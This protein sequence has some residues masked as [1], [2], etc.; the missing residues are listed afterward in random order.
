MD[1]SKSSASTQRW[2][3]E[4]LAA[5]TQQQRSLRGIADAVAARLSQCPP[6]EEED[7]LRALRDR[8]EAAQRHSAAA[9]QSLVPLSVAVTAAP[10][11][12][13][14]LAAL[15]EERCRL[16]RDIHDGP[17]Q[18]LANALLELQYCQRLLERDPGALRG[19]LAVLSK[20]L[21]D[22]LVEVRRLIFDLRPP[23]LVEL[24]LIAAI[25][26]YVAEYGART[27][28]EASL[29]VRGPEE[30]LSPVQEAAVFRILQEALQNVRRHA[31]ARRVTVEIEDAPD[32]WRLSV[33]DDGVG[34]DPA[35]LSEGRRT[36]GL[37]SMRERAQA[38]GAALEVISRPGAGTKVL[39]TLPATIRQ[40]PG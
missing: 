7:D 13:G 35:R 19:E 30:R 33:S 23:A 39:L 17:A 20:C 15:E 1:V 31:G 22:G 34:F 40:V 9:Y 5:I 18:V 38:I 29:E 4:A 28:I 37:T 8:L 11:G 14:H 3:D 27:G 21:R 6:D 26:N 24:G 25:R 12:Q 32:Y 10:P 16:A 36:L 2:L